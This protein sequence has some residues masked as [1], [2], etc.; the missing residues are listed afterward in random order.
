MSSVP[1]VVR[2]SSD[3]A[4][5]TEISYTVDEDLLIKSFD[6]SLVTDATVANR[7]VQI[8][9]EDADGNVYFRGVAGG[10][11]AASLTRKYAARP[12]EYAAPAVADDVFVVPLPPGGL[13]IPRNGKLKTATT[14]RQSGDNFGALTLFAERF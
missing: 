10:V 12:G 4:A 2:K 9:A 11:Q 1:F 7:Q 5:N 6:V 13:F 14:A 8:T 3:P